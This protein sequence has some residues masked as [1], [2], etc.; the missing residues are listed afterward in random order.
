[1]G[2][3]DGR[4][5]AIGAVSEDRKG[6]VGDQPAGRKQ[7]RRGL[8]DHLLT[9]VIREDRAQGTGAVAPRSRLTQ[10]Q[11]RAHLPSDPVVPTSNH[12]ALVAG[13]GFDPSLESETGQ[14][15]DVSDPGIGGGGA[16][17][18]SRQTH[19]EIHLS[20]H[21]GPDIGQVDGLARQGVE[22]ESIEGP[23]GCQARLHEVG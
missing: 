21:L 6:P 9:F 18:I 10:Q 19:S 7:T 14:I 17:S 5:G 12:H 13:F 22:T 15:A 11:H 3:L 2:E 23:Q 8:E 1:M 20:I 16:R 4:V